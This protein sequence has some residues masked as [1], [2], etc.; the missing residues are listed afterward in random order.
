MHATGKKQEH[1]G[2]QPRLRLDAWEYA[3]YLFFGRGVMHKVQGRLLPHESFVRGLTWA[4]LSRFSCLDVAMDPVYWF[5]HRI[6][7]VIFFEGYVDDCTIAG[8]ITDDL[9]WVRETRALY[10]MVL[11]RVF[12]FRID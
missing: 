5:L 4:A 2:R 3:C 12:K 6:P 10:G 11:V 8:D 1:E 9:R 7:R